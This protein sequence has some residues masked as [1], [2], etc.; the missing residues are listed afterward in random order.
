MTGERHPTPAERLLALLEDEQTVETLPAGEVRAELA[1]LGVD[2]SR[3]VAFARALAGGA[4]SPGARLLGSIDMA[5]EEEDEIARLESADI[6]EVRARIPEGSAATIAAA[7][8]RQAGADSNV[9][10]MKPRRSR[11]LRWGGPL[12]G[13]A[14]SVLVAAVLTLQY[15]NPARQTVSSEVESYATAPQ[16]ESPAEPATRAD[17]A[18]SLA[19]DARPEAQ[20]QRRAAPPGAAADTE[21]LAKQEFRAAAPP[22]ATPEAPAS[23]LLGNVTEEP[24]LADRP[25]DDLRARQPAAETEGAGAVSEQLAAKPDTKGKPVGGIPAIAATVIVDPS[26]VSPAVQSQAVPQPDLAARI[27]E[28]RRL[29]G[30]RPV[31][32]LYRI[33]GPAGRQDF[34]QVPLAP[35]MT[36][37]MPAP[38]PLTQLLGPAAQDYD[39]LALPSQ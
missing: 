1:G 20:N 33:A 10:A 35:A 5:E 9:V 37:Q 14:A 11:I 38:T 15:L 19:R 2:P 28:A 24:A 32:A 31:I 21:R 16:V 26:Q 8:R 6:G 22:A 27:D 34:A 30:N 29:A 39:F 18:D 12:A 23:G 4:G 17:E 13:I 3:C 36:Q 7:A 25:A